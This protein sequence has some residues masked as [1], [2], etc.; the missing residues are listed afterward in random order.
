MIVAS[1]ERL[2]IPF[3]FKLYDRAVSNPFFKARLVYKL[4]KE[5][6]LVFFELQPL[7]PPL[8]RYVAVFL[9]VL[10]YFWLSL[11]LLIPAG[12]IILMELFFQDF[13]YK[14]LIGRAL[15]KE[16]YSLTGISYLKRR[17]AFERLLAWD[18]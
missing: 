13:F 5:E 8:H 4:K 17:E 9:G 2:Y 3:F 18:R 15:R 11:W 7:I 1:I 14:F 10:A 16:K 6:G 12:F